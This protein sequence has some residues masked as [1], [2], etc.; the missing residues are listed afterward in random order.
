MARYLFD[1]RDDEKLIPDRGAL[2]SLEATCCKNS[3]RLI[4]HT[5]KPSH[6]QYN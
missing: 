6:R 3:R 2:R 4:A 1:Y 5:Y